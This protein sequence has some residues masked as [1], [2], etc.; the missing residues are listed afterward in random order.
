MMGNLIDLLTTRLMDVISELAQL[1]LLGLCGMCPPRPSFNA[2]ER[3]EFHGSKLD[4]GR[5]GGITAFSF[6][7]GSRARGAPFRSIV[8]MRRSSFPPSVLLRPTSK[9]ALLLNE[10]ISMYLMN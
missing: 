6:S 2:P 4:G 9:A 3:S 8:V 5:K 10:S 1:V 7:L